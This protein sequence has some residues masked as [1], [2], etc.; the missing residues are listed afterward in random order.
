[1]QYSHGHALH[2]HTWA[3]PSALYVGIWGSGGTPLLILNL[4][5]VWRWSASPADRFTPATEQPYLL[6]RRLCGPP[7]PVRTI[8]RRYEYFSIYICKQNTFCVLCII[9]TCLCVYMYVCMYVCMY[10][11]VTNFYGHI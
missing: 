4:G 2:K 1:M 6:N 8:W 7:K 11:A 3:C 10:V 5:T 9:K